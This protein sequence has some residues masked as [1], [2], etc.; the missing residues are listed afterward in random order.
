MTG[1]GVATEAARQLVSW[2]F[3][4]TGLVRLEVVVACG[5]RASLAVARKLGAHPEGRQRLR[6]KLPGGR[7]DAE[8]FAIVRP[9]VPELPAG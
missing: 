6:L 9:G 8:L 2:A 1:R 7:S 4:E 5:N 3:R